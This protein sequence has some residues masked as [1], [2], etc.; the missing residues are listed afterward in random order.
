MSGD[1]PNMPTGEIRAMLKMVMETQSITRQEITE[2]KN[3][4]A[5][6]VRLD[7]KM[8]N[9]QAGL[10]RIGTQVDEQRKVMGGVLGRLQKLESKE[11]QRTGL[12]TW[13]V[14]ILSALVTGIVM[15]FTKK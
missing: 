5:L 4:M 9:Q 1:T 12:V 13:L 3:S 8:V 2:I 7:E 11:T 15:W 6:L 14:G 10:H